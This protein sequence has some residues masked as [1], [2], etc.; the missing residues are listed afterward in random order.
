MRKLIPLVMLA[1]ALVGCAATIPS[2]YPASPYGVPEQA[3][4]ACHA[5]KGV[6]IQGW[7]RATLN[8]SLARMDV[9][10]VT[11]RFGKTLTVI[12]IWETHKGILWFW[13]CATED[14]AP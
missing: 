12:S 5:K 10:R 2:L 6:V 4:Q 14:Y 3:V 7:A 8:N 13:V 11:A 1:L 9:E